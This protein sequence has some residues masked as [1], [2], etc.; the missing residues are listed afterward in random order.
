MS[1]IITLTTDFGLHDEYVGVMKGVILSRSPSSVI[2]DLSHSVLPQNIMQAGYCIHASYN[3]F[4]PGTVHVVVVDPGVGSKRRIIL[5][6][7][8]EHLFLAPDNGVLSILINEGNCGE[9]RLVSCEEIFLFPLSTTFHGRDIFAPVAAALA[10]GMD[11]Q[12]VGPVISEDSLV[13]FCFPNV[14]I[15][16][17]ESI[18]QGQ[19]T[20][21]DH[22]GNLVTNVREED[23]IRAGLADATD[24]VQIL[25]GNGI[26][27]EM[28]LSYAD[29][30]SGLLVAVFGGRGYLEIAQNCGN[31]A[32]LLGVVVGGTIRIEKK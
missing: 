7:I 2:V 18:I 5:A 25:V 4:P 16:E 20:W 27:A 11:I 31:A 17:Q 12:K 22:F 15:A 32:E 19:V 8:R 24:S 23:F 26:V 6:K 10:T 28:A 9:Y 3:F 29:V 30:E 1:G 21:V 14:E 13:E